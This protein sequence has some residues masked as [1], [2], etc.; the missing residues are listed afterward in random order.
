MTSEL[1]PAWPATTREISISPAELVRFL[2]VLCRNSHT[3]RHTAACESLLETW[4]PIIAFQD[5]KIPQRGIGD[6]M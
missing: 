2:D 3:C 5:I 6:L 1:G 4:K